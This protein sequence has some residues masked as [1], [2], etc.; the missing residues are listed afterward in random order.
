ERLGPVP[1]ATLENLTANLD[2]KMDGLWASHKPSPL[3]RV[4]KMTGKA[5]LGLAGLGTLYFASGP[6]YHKILSLLNGPAAGLSV[7]AELSP[8]DQPIASDRVLAT[9]KDS[10]EPIVLGKKKNAPSLKGNGLSNEVKVQGLVAQ[11]SIDSSQG[12]KKAEASVPG[13]SPPISPGALANTQKDLAATLPLDSKGSSGSSTAEGD[14]LR[15]AINTPKTQNVVVTVF[16]TNGL[17]IRHLYQGFLA[18]GEH[19]VDW[20]G[21]DELGNAVLPGDYTVVLDLDGKKM[22]GILKVLPNK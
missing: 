5:A 15:V 17:L 19:Y 1:E 12:S 4:L 9:P 22:S 13:N 7:Q 2:S 20:D 16:D 10:K 21:K 8:A 14:A 18:A 3:I 6:L 11:G